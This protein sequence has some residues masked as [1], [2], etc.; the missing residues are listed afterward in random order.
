[1][2]IEIEKITNYKLMAQAMGFTSDKDIKMTP[3]KAS[4]MFKSEHS[5]IRTQMYAIRMYD[6]PTYVS[7]HLCR[8]KIGVEHFVKSN[9]KAD[10][11]VTR[12]TLVNHMMFLNAQAL[13]NMSHSRLCHTSS[14]ET[15]EVME[16]I[17]KQIY[18]DDPLFGQML[19]PKCWYR[20][21]RCFEKGNCQIC[22]MKMNTM[23]HYVCVLNR[24][25]EK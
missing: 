23:L 13:I 24:L 6:I 21:G 14:K 5:P 16:E 2:K 17:A 4:Q 1:M 19:E 22:E 20:G 10:D 18:A 15:R 12:D 25:E 11:V 9:R 8:H 7:V 3:N